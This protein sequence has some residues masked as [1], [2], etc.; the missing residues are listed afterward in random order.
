MP[1]LANPP[2]PFSTANDR[3]IPFYQLTGVNHACNVCAVTGLQ[4]PQV[5]SGCVVFISPVLAL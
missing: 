5:V 3:I 2:E 1:L 4:I